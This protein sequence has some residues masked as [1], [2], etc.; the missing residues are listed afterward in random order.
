MR[1]A[2]GGE[3]TCNACPC[4]SLTPLAAEEVG[5][6]DRLVCINTEN[7]IDKK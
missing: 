6:A 4:E 7:F 2:D 1:I 5:D 3:S